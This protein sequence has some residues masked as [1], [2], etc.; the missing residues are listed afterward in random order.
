MS[1]KHKYVDPDKGFIIHPDMGNALRNYK[2][3]ETIAEV[4]EERDEAVAEG[5]EYWNTD[6]DAEMLETARNR[7]RDAGLIGDGW[8][9]PDPPRRRKK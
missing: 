9:Y 3:K 7:S 4:L 2:G 8:E 6:H 1:E 5:D